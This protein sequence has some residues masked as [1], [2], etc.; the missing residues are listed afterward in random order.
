MARSGIALATSDVFLR[1]IGLNIDPHPPPQVT[2]FS[3]PTAGQGVPRGSGSIK[4]GKVLVNVTAFAPPSLAAQA[5]TAES[6]QLG[7]ILTI[8][9]IS[10]SEVTH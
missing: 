4:V 2:L 3:S 6:G 10:I 1:A 5:I 8:T 7:V 9:G